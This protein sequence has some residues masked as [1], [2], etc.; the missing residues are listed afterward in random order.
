MYIYT[1]V[2]IHT[3]SLVQSI[4]NK[5]QIISSRFLILKYMLPKTIVMELRLVT[6]FNMKGLSATPMVYLRLSEG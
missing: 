5:V 6:K 4:F 1:Y 2:Y 3:H